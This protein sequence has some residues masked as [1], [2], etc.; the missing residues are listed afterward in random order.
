MA[1]PN[2]VAPPMQRTSK[3]RS[4]LAGCS[5]TTMASFDKTSPDDQ[6]KRVRSGMVVFIIILTSSILA[7]TAWSVPLGAPGYFVGIVWFAIM[8]GI[9]VSVLQ[10]MDSVSFHLMAQKMMARDYSPEEKNRVGAWYVVLRL[11]LILVICYFNSEMVRVIMFK[12]EIVAA[13][14]VQQDKETSFIIDSLHNQKVEVK[15]KIEKK[16]DEYQKSNQNLE[17]LIVAYDQKIT[18][19]DDSLNYWNS[20]LVHEVKGPG[21]VS[22]IT[23]DGPVSKAIRET[24]NRYGAMKMELIAQ[25]DSAKTQSVAS[26]S[27]SIAERELKEER[28]R[29][30][31]AIADIDTMEKRLVQQVMDRPVNGLSF[32]IS[33]L[34]DIAK[35]NWLIWAVF[36]MFFFIEAIPVLMKF[37]SKNDSFIQQRAIE[38]MKSVEDTTRQASDINDALDDLKKKGAAAKP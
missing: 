18:T 30:K 16:E 2:P 9:E 14:K 28:V 29:A 33:V 15:K 20:K 24:I 1:N 11:A 35:R 38:Y 23:G 17:Q 5:G 8:W 3:L 10:Q 21:G 19:I 25:R 13:I 34:N 4:F 12:P 7:S 22:G 27:V 36:G 31:E 26:N 37:F 32:M 6:Q